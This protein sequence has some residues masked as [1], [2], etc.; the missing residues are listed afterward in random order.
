MDGV[1]YGIKFGG[2]FIEDDVLEQLHEIFIKFLPPDALGE[3]CDRL[4]PSFMK[5][6]YEDSGLDQEVP[7]LY[8][9]IT[10]MT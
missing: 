6:K 1:F 3:A 4:D 2:I 10:W 9:M 8:A 7:S 5:R